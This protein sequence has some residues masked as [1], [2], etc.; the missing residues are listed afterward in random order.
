MPS[1]FSQRIFNKLSEVIGKGPIPFEQITFGQ[2]LSF[3]K[4]E[5]ISLCNEWKLQARYS[6][7]KATKRK[8]LGSFCE[9][10]CLPKLE[11]PSVKQWRKTQ[12]TKKKQY[13]TRNPNYKRLSPK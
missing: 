8:E 9:A 10:F 1:L 12:I 4:K 3:I 13:N 11:A 2:L 7:D 5:E 6:T